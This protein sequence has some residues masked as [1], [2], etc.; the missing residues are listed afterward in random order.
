MDKEAGLHSRALF[1]RFARTLFLSLSLFL[2]SSLPL[3]QWVS[4]CGLLQPAFAYFTASD[5]PSAS[6]L[7]ARRV[8]A[9]HD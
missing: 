2:S 5:G 7:A 9:S 6:A 8:S 4:L 1:S 3:S